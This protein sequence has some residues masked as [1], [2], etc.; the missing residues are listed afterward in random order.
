VYFTFKIDLL[1][2]QQENE[3]FT[4]RTTRLLETVLKERRPHIASKILPLSRWRKLHRRFDQVVDHFVNSSQKSCSAHYSVCLESAVENICAEYRR[5]DCRTQMDHYLQTYMSYY[6]N[7]NDLKASGSKKRYQQAVDIRTFV[8]NIEMWLQIPLNA[9]RIYREEVLHYH[10]VKKIGIFNIEQ[11]NDKARQIY[12]CFITGDDE[13]PK[14]TTD[15]PPVTEQI[16]MAVDIISIYERLKNI[17]YIFMMEILMR[18]NLS[19][20]ILYSSHRVNEYQMV[21]NRLI[22]LWIGFLDEILWKISIVNYWIL[23]KKSNA[24]KKRD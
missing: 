22:R 3:N 16:R 2:S 1:H 21:S 12:Q 4:Q 10:I 24:K 23:S 6:S 13:L 14:T 7:Q 11:A 15:I 20:E 5:N 8:D 18:H 19:F 17:R 9:F